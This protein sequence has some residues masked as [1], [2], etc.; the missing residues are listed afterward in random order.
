MDESHS[1]IKLPKLR[2]I[3][4]SYQAAGHD[5]PAGRRGKAGG[6]GLLL[7][8]LPEDVAGIDPEQ[9]RAQRQGSQGDP[10]RPDR[11]Q[12]GLLA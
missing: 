6:R 3:P 2:V 9:D 8:Q 7:A 4:E 5:E 10:G 11:G 12:Q 1:K